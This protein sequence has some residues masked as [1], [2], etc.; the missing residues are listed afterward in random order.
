MLPHG[1]L[2]IDNIRERLLWRCFSLQSCF[3]GCDMFVPWI[4]AVPCSSGC[5]LPGEPRTSE[6]RLSAASFAWS[7]GIA[8]LQIPRPTPMPSARRGPMQVLHHSIGVCC[9]C[10][11]YLC[12][13]CS[14]WSP[15]F[16]CCRSCWS[17]PYHCEDI[18]VRTGL[19]LDVYLEFSLSIPY[20]CPLVSPA[21]A[22]CSPSLVSDC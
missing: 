19:G 4:G 15:T 11:W 3:G 22:I 2:P 14:C 12:R 10:C 16:S 7:P 6:Q 9:C 1:G 20:S 18:I 5:S 8:L 21:S 17:L 13:C